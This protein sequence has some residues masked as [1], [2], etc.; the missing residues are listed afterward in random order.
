MNTPTH[1]LL[2]LALLSEKAHPLSKNGH[3]KRNLAVFFGSLIPD[4]AIFVW[5]PY[6][7]LVNGISG[8][9][10]WN[11]LY[12]LPPM[13]NLI[14]W[15]NSVPIYA[16]LALIGFI[17]FSKTWGKLLFFFALAALIHMATDF[18]IHADD[19][20]RHFWP[21]SDWR[22]VSPLSYWDNNHHAPWIRL[23]EA[24][25]AGICIAVLWYRFPKRW[26]KITLFLLSLFYGLL[27]TFSIFPMIIVYIVAGLFIP[28]KRKRT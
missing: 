26:V 16:A 13:Q 2:A 19:A 21:L 22:F 10:L 17:T 9:V 23:I 28:F 14:A 20:Y 12:F 1:T 3:R 18:P 24:G 11:K 4:L 27:V 7:R 15:F 5:A 8:D 25:V 6:Q